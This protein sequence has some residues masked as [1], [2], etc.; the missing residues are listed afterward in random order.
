MKCKYTELLG[1]GMRYKLDTSRFVDNFE[2]SHL[3]ILFTN[4][5]TF[6]L[7]MKVFRFNCKNSFKLKDT[8]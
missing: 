4:K 2:Y 1:S 6:N 3:E 8:S 5:G 7:N